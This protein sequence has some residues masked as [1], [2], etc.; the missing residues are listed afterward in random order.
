MV[1]GAVCKFMMGLEIKC[2]S[3]EGTYLTELDS[4]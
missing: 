2:L 4:F 3:P 1:G